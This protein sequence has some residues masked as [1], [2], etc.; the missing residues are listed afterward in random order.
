MAELSNPLLNNEIEYDFSGFDVNMDDLY[1]QNAQRGAST[2]AVW[3]EETGR[4]YLATVAPHSEM[5]LALSGL[6]V[7]DITTVDYSE[8]VY[9]VG[10]GSH[11]LG[12]VSRKW[13]VQE[14][15]TVNMTEGWMTESQL[16]E[17]WNADEGMGYFKKANPDMTFDSYFAMV[18]D[19]TTRYQA[20]GGLMA[21][22]QDNFLADLAADHGVQTQWQNS[23]G[24][25]FNFTGS[26]YAKSYKVDDHMS[27]GDWMKTVMTAAVSA[28][29]AAAMAPVLASAIPGLNSATAKALINSAIGI[30]KD[31]EVS[32]TDAFALAGANIPGVGALDEMTDV[33]QAVIDDAI[34]AVVDEILNQDN[35]GNEGNK[36]V[37]KPTTSEIINEGEQNENDEFEEDFGVDVNIPIP[38][39]PMDDSSSG[40][41]GTDA[42]TDETGGSEESTGGEDTSSDAGGGGEIGGGADWRYENGVWTNGTDIIQGPGNEGDTM[43]DEEMAGAWE[44]G[45]YTWGGDLGEGGL[46]DGTDGTDGDDSGTPDVIVP[47]LP[48][49]GSGTTGGDTTGGGET[50]GET[51][52]GDEEGGLGEIVLGGGSGGTGGT[53]G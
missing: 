42:E 48:G 41:G 19:G 22:E 44:S 53:G 37:F 39:Y 12:E 31:G 50:D 35:Y 26:G 13:D 51:E 29:A 40:G 16:R 43:S 6:T 34:G 1:G 45:D 9:F 36:P 38:E 2:H 4:Y 8:P 49:G 25:V 20:A 5:D 3:D 24:D 7:E 27:P 33:S 18:Q 21:G 23:D 28:G 47:N 11:E 14:S 46:E 32:L 30:A 52:G 17:Q 15:G 10:S